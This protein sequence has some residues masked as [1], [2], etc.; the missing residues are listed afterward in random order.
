MD[1][2]GGVPLLPRGLAVVLEDLEDD[3][4]ERFEDR[5]PLGEGAAIAGRLGVGEDLFE[6]LPVDAIRAAGGALAQAV[7]EDAT[8]DLGPVLHVGV[9][10]QTSRR[11]DQDGR[12]NLHRGP[13]AMSDAMGVPFS[14]RPSVSPTPRSVFSATVINSSYWQAP[15]VPRGDRWDRRILK[16][17]SQMKMKI[18]LA[19]RKWRR[20]PITPSALIPNPSITTEVGSGTAVMMPPRFPGAP[21]MVGLPKLDPATE[22][23]IVP[24]VVDPEEM[25]YAFV[26]IPVPLLTDVSV[27]VPVSVTVPIGVAVPGGGTLVSEITSE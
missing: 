1:P 16:D 24:A 18:Y 27:I 17:Q 21:L 20:L 2:H 8:A 12:L 25:I 26:T 6:G 22:K 3:R 19:E 14:D 5:G 10:P 9:H 11:K 4:Q 15:S 13:V 7:D 23:G